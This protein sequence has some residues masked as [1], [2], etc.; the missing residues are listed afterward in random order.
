MSILNPDDQGQNPTQPPG[1]E[2]QGGDQP[3]APTGD[4]PSAPP[5]PPT[6]GESAAPGEKCVTCGNAA[7]GGNC[8]ACGQ[9]EVSCPCQPAPGGGTP[10]VGEQPTGAPAV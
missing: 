10:P 1:G 6:G 8:V 7:S 3:A 5:Q 2:P 4:Q 9:G